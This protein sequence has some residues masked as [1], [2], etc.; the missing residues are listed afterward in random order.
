MFPMRSS[1]QKINPSWSL[2]VRNVSLS[3][4]S[5][6]PMIY[7]CAKKNVQ[8]QFTNDINQKLISFVGVIVE[9]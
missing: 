5:R 4:V 1:F 2:V 6:F 7:F 9:F 3:N 8:M